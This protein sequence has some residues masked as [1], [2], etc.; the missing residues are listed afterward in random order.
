[1]YT[2]GPMRW[3]A[4][5]MIQK[6]ISTL[7]RGEAVN[8][9]IQ[10]RV[11]RTL[12]VPDNRL[13]LRVDVA[14]N[15]VRHYAEHGGGSLESA[16]A[17]E[18]GAGWELIGPMTLWMAGVERQ[19][20]VDV[21]PH[22]RLPLINH[23]LERFAR[24]HGEI[25]ARAGRELRRVP[26]APLESLADLERR[27]GIV[28]EAP[29]D[30]RDTGMEAGSF[31]LITSTWVLQHVPRA[32]IAAILHESARLLSP[33][34]VISHSI[35]M[36]DMFAFA[37]PRISVWNFLRYGDRTWSLVNSSLQFQNRLRARDY[38]DLFRDAGLDL[39]VERPYVPDDVSPL[40]ALDLADRFKRDYAFEDLMPT[41]LLAAARHPR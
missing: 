14:L 34:G 4:K 25:E 27:F 38:L 20:L 28:Y 9:A 16:R 15:H 2:G 26:T 5:A 7:P 32:D 6:G 17:F 41:T 35:D 36:Q 8:Y 3:V 19:L 23:T 39:V 37:D 31:D 33:G 22:V 18:L 12:P 10:R 21:E 40:E 1:L 29:R 24:L 30:A 11:T 13:L